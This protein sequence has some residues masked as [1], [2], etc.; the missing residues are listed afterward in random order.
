MVLDNEHSDS[1]PVT[2]GVPQGSVLGPI[3]FL[4]YI[5]D[6]SEKTKYKV[7]LFVDDT[8][9]Y[10]ALSSIQDARLLQDD[11][12]RL[13]QWE[14]DWDMEFNPSKCTVIHVSRSRSPLSVEYHLHGQVLESVSSSKYLVWTSVTISPGINTYKG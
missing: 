1:V 10:L 11:L 5:N 14:L 9:L 6:L 4:I 12:N 3:L 8:A 2:S 7:R 13:Q